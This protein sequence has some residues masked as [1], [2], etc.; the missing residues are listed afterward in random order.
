MAHKLPEGGRLFSIEF[1][2]DNAAIA[3]KIISHAGLSDRIEVVLGTLG[4]SGQTISNL[5]AVG[6]LSAGMLDFAFIDHAKD[7]YVPDLMLILERG[8]L[9]RGSVVV[10]D[11]I[12]VPGA[13]EYHAY[14]KEQEGKRW[15]TRKHKSFVEH[16]SVVPDLVLESDYPGD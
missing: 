9:H 2:K 10:A 12:K 15:R 5:E 4:G 11:N 14:M 3:R 16:E 6:A 7:A 1:N 13:P 8:W